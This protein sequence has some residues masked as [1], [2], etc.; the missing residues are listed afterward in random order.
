VTPYVVKPV[1]GPMA[2]PNDGL[3][4]PTDSDMLSGAMNH[5]Q[6]QPPTIPAPMPA[7]AVTTLPDG[8]KAAMPLGQVG[9]ELD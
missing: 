9:F 4:P 2:T 6:T 7:A 8:R 3:E 1:N 5:P